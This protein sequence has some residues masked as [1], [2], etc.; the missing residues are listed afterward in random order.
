MVNTFKNAQNVLFKQGLTLL[1][2]LKDSEIIFS[3]QVYRT[4][5]C[6]FIYSHSKGDSLNV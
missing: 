4:Y 1:I 5:S 2:L 6:R 3:Q